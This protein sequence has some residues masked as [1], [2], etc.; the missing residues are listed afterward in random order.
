MHAQAATD[1]AEAFRI[2]PN[3]YDALFN[4]AVTY[5]AL[6]AW[7][8]SRDVYTQ[9]AGKVNP[10]QNSARQRLPYIEARKAGQ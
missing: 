1:F 10:F 2:D 7:D 5:E 3:R 9:L 6:G 8:Q 4:L